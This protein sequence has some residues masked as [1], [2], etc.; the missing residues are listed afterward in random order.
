M[1]RSK[2]IDI[3]PNA[4]RHQLIALFEDYL[5]KGL[6]AIEEDAGRIYNTY[7]T[8]A[9]NHILPK[10]LTKA[11]QM[12]NPIAWKEVAEISHTKIAS[13]EAF[14]EMLQLLNQEE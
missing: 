3:N 10:D 6:P 7:Y 9:D 12:L 2:T 4:L 14:Q 8:A 5:A 13:K 1:N 11:V